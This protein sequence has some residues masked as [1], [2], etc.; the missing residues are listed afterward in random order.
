METIR[1]YLENMFSRLPRTPEIIKLE[2]DMLRTM[3]DKYEELKMEGKSENEAIG[4]VISEFGNIDE[5]IDELGLLSAAASGNGEDMGN[6]GFRETDN[7][8]NASGS[9]QTGGFTDY[10]SGDIYLS[11]DQVEQ[12]ISDTRKYHRMMGIGIALCII[13]PALMILLG[14]IFSPDSP[15]AAGFI[16]EF[17]QI[18]GLLMLFPLFLCL[19]AGLSLIIYAG[20]RLDQYKFLKHSNLIVSPSLQSFIIS[21]QADFQPQNVVITT[22][23]IVLCILAPFILIVISQLGESTFLGEENGGTIGVFFMLLLI[24]IAVYLFVTSS[25]EEEIYKT[26]LQEKKRKT[27]KKEERLRHSSNSTAKTISLI[28]SVYWPLVTCFYFFWSFFIGSWA[29]SWIIWILASVVRNILCSI[30]KDL[31]PE[32]KK[33]NKK[34]EA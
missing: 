4:I 33:K 21:M 20:S 8:G 1:I 10:D 5:L 2:N 28:L 24:A 31:E 11:R 19:A 22:V 23:G 7:H 16:L 9:R 26:L 34:K 25:G 12:V 13:G 30:L 18:H 15:G 29:T 27:E 14:G 6:G 17:S 3:E 32:K